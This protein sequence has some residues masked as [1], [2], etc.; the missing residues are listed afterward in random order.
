MSTA[1]ACTPDD[2]VERKEVALFVP[3]MR[4]KA[5]KPQCLTQ[6]FVKFTLRLTT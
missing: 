3:Y 5:Q 2:F 4:L 6:T 1:S